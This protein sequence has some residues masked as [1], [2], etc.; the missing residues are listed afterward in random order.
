MAWLRKNILLYHKM[1]I[2]LNY[3]LNPIF[4]NDSINS[5]PIEFQTKGALEM[6]EKIVKSQPTQMFAL[7]HS[8]A[9]PCHLPTSKGYER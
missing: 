1:K 4:R 5:F 2:G 7:N 6:I 3:F 9:Y 8:H